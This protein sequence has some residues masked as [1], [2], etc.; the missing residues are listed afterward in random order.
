M[1]NKQTGE[2]LQREFSSFQANI[3]GLLNRLD[4]RTQRMDKQMDTM[5]HDICG[6]RDALSRVER[7]RDDS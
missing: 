1:D 6:L 5:A 3:T 4:E 7:K 2:R